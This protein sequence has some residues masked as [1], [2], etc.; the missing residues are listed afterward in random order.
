MIQYDTYILIY[1][2]RKIIYL[3]IKYKIRQLFYYKMRQ[4]ITKYV[5]I[6]IT[7]CD[8]FIT[9]CNSYYKMRQFY[10]KLRRLLQFA[11]VQ[12]PRILKTNLSLEK[13]VLR[14]ASIYKLS[15]RLFTTAFFYIYF[16]II[17]SKKYSKKF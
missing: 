11:T 10:Y 4:V 8:S 5:R 3:L 14:K 2:M 16:S 6:F 15:D 1:K 13:S 9:K 7:K 17:F 12:I